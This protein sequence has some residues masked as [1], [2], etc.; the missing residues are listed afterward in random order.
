MLRFRLKELIADKS[1]NEGRRVTLD[2]IAE[3]TG[4]NRTTLSKIGSQKGYN[5]TSNNLDA[6][7]AYFDCEIQ[8]LVQRVR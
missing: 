4:I 7:C 8:D 2:E 1:F 6:L 3:Q 5:T